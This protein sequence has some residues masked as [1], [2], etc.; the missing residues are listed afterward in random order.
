MLFKRHCNTTDG[1]NKMV[2]QIVTLSIVTSLVIDLQ[3]ESIICKHIYE[4]LAII[5]QYKCTKFIQ[6]Q[7]SVP[8]KM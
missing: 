1:S 3:E 6:I 7:L 4:I 5:I 8:G 2:N